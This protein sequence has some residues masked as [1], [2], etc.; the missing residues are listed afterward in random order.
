MSTLFTPTKLGFVE[1]QN[2]FIHSATYEGMA[3][4]TGE[5]TD[6]ILKRYRNLAKGEVGLIIPGY[7]YVLRHGREQAICFCYCNSAL[8]ID[9]QLKPIRKRPFVLLNCFV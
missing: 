5:V 8:F 9:L 3:L 2:R 6:E 1:V 4:A 7:M